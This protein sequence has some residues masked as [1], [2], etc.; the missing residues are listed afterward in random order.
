MTAGDI[1]S[2]PDVAGFSGERLTRL[3]AAMQIEVEAGHIPGAMLLI[4]R[5]GETVL[6]RAWGYR[7]RQAGTM[8]TADTI[9]RIYS[10][11]KPIVSVAAMM[12]AAEGRLH[13]GQPI[14]DFIPAFANT[15]V[16]RDGVLAGPSNLPTVQDL[17]RHTS[18]LTYQSN[19]GAVADLY[20]QAGLFSADVTNEEFANRLAALPF[21]HEPGRVWEYGHSTD[22]LGR[23]VEAAS[24]WPLS[25]FLTTRILAPLGMYDTGFFVANEAR[26][27][28]IAEPLPGESVNGRGPLFDPRCERAFEAGGMGLVSTVDDY[29]RFARM[30]L[31]GGALGKTMILGKRTMRFMASDHIGPSTGI[32]KQP[33][34]MPGPGYGFGLGF[35]VRLEPG[36]AISPGSP[37]EFHWT[38]VAGTSFWI[39]PVEDLFV[40]LLTQAPSQ[41]MRLRAM[42]KTMVYDALVGGRSLRV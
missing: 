27:N 20:G 16:L 23:V 34:Y 39:D 15:K 28:R 31:A 17:L 6:K 4:E 24:G 13:L 29:A 19:G 18:G 40:I 5:Q 21:A 11:T 9:F 1:V 8:M 32:V 41:R 30:L 35:A 26:H 37:G 10:M 36:A 42:V 14:S 12:L 3:D 22:I 2:F 7:D 38:G 25:A 33:D